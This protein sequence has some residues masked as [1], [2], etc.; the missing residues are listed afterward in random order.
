MKRFLLFIIIALLGTSI[1]IYVF[2]PGAL[3]QLAQTVERGKAD[4]TQK[5]VQIDSFNIVYLESGDR[6][7]ETILFVHGFGADKDNWTR[8]AK[9]F[10]QNYHL[11]ALDL[12]GFGESTR[13]PAQTYGSPKQAARLH[14]FVQA[15]GLKRFHIVGNSMGG[16]IAALYTH[17]HPEHVISLGLF[18]NAGITTPEKSDMARLLEQGTNPLLVNNADDFDRMMNFVFVV[19]PPVPGVIKDHFAQ[20]A[21]EFRPFNEKIFKEYRVNPTPL[22]PILPEIKQPTFILWGDQDRLLHVSSVDVMTPLLPNSK[23]VIMKH[24]GHAPMIERPAET[25][26]HYQTF[27]DTVK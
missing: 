10:Y 15:I 11:V 4:L 20:R 2:F 21:V 16:H 3:L 19:P 18:N 23:A 17:Q 7:N 14:K 1:A 6:N 26:K 8:L 9:H 24:C 27:L 22:E 25:A 12:P 5:N 13:D